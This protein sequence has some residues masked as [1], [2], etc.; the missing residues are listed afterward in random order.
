[1]GKNGVYGGKMEIAA[2]TGIYNVSVSICSVSEGQFTQPSADVLCEVA[3]QAK[4]LCWIMGNKT[5]I[6]VTETR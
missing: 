5:E 3:A 6:I 4:H 2:V 1:M